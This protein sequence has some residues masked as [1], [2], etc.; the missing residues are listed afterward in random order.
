MC[1]RRTKLSQ[2]DNYRSAIHQ[3]FQNPLYQGG[4]KHQD[5]NDVGISAGTAPSSP[6]NY[7]KGINFEAI[8][9]IVACIKDRFQQ[10]GYQMYCKL[11]QLL[12]NEEQMEREVDEVLRFYGSDF[13]SQT[14]LTQLHLFYEKNLYV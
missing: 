3:T 5:V 10:E 14:L 13:E 12:L 4:V 8:D 6:E 11:E 9:A 1:C 7:Y 2:Y